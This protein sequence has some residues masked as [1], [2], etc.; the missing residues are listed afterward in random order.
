M[1]QLSRGGECT[2]HVLLV[3]LSELSE[4]LTN[5]RSPSHIYMAIGAWIA[6]ANPS[7]I[8]LTYWCLLRNGLVGEE[9][10]TVATSSTQEPD[11]RTSMRNQTACESGVFTCCK[12]RLSSDCG[13]RDRRSPYDIFQSDKSTRSPRPFSWCGSASTA[14]TCAGH[15]IGVEAGAGSQAVAACARLMVGW[16]T[17]WIRGETGSFRENDWS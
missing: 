1:S 8:V 3:A 2:T 9:A 11:S 17:E 7:Q 10:S 16:R 6:T 14:G 15:G 4:V 12:R 13:R 5:A